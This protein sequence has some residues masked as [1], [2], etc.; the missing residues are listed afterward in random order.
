MIKKNL[1]KT[2]GRFIF[3][4]LKKVHFMD[5]QFGLE[6]PTNWLFIGGQFC[7][8]PFPKIK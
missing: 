5:Q 8:I 2:F 1:F 4:K 3:A 6:R 7:L